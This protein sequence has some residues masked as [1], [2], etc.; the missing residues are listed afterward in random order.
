MVRVGFTG[1]R[2]YVPVSWLTTLG[3]TPEFDHF[4]LLDAFSCWGIDGASRS[5]TAPILVPYPKS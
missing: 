3:R 1:F 5:G 4:L 2:V